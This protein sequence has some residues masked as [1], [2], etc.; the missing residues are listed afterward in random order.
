MRKQNG[1]ARLVV[2][3]ASASRVTSVARGFLSDGCTKGQRERGDDRPGKY[4]G[5]PLCRAGIIRFKAVRTLEPRGA[6]VKNATDAQDGYNMRHMEH[7]GARLAKSAGGPDKRT[8][9]GELMK[10]FL[11]QVNMARVADGFRAM[12]MGHMGKLLQKIPT[13]DLY[14][15]K[16]VCDNSKNFSKKFWWEINPKKHEADESKPF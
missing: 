6:G 2:N 14:Y 16:S 12:S 13:K 8:E 3:R 11:E 10:Y 9:R 15:L 4:R 5:G 7:I 1:W